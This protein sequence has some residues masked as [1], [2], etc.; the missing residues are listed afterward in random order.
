MD[1]FKQ[2]NEEIL[3]PMAQGT[4]ALL[5]R[6]RQLDAIQFLEFSQGHNANGIRLKDILG[7][8]KILKDNTQAFHDG[9]R[10]GVARRLLSCAP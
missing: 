7:A 9:S 10:E 6:C 2:R 8:R 4:W 3:F 1:R 5:Q